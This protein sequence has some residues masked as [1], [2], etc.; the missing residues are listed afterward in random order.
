MHI[1]RFS[2]RQSAHCESGVTANMI[3]HYYQDISEALAFGMGS[4]LFFAY[5]PFIRVNKLPLATFRTSPGAIF[6]NVGKRLQLPVKVEHFST[7]KKAEQ[8]LDVS[9]E[10]GVPVVL[11]TGVY[12][13]P[14][15][16]P[17]L[18]FHFNAH[19]LV[20]YGREGDEY[21]IS[22]PV[23]EN[24]VRCHRDDLNR[25][26]FAAGALAPKGKMSIMGLNS[27]SLDL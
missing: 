9:L 7:V 5:L 2:H 26:R 24:P 19:N 20:V 22:D 14:Y 23:F 12:W 27:G 3:S 8:A 17:A 16:P 21:L 10:K 1:T 4:G 25:A 15:F 11:Q 6:K 18:R 13:L